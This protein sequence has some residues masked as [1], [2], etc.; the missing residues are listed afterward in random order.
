MIT[1]DPSQ[2][3]FFDDDARVIAV[4]WHRQ[5][6]KDFV[7]AGKAVK[8]A[9]RRKGD[10]FITSLTQ[11]Q[12][13]ASFSKADRFVEAY[14]TVLK[15]RGKVTASEEQFQEYDEAIDHTF[16]RTARTLTLPNGNRVVSLPG[17]NPDTLAGLTGNII[18]TEFGL[19]PQGGYNH[20]RV[21]FPLTTRGYQACLVSTPRSKKTKYYEICS[22]PDIYSVHTCPITRSVAEDGYVLRDNKGNPCTLEAFKKLYNDD[23]GWQREYECQFTGDLDSL[24]TWA[25]LMSAQDGELAT[26]VIH[27]EG[28]NG[29][30]GSLIAWLQAQPAGRFELGW[31]VARTGHLSSLWINHAA[32][33]GKKRLAA[34]VLMH[35]CRFE[36]Q[37]SIIQAVM[38][39]RPGSV[40]AGDATGLGN[41]SNE[42]LATRYR[43]NWQPIVFNGKSKSELGSLGKTAYGDGVQKLPSFTIDT[44]LKFIATDVYSIQCQP[45]GDAADKRLALSETEN[46]LEPRSHCDIAY[47]NLLALFA[48]TLAGG[49]RGALPRPLYEKP[50][51]W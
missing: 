16:T 31:D 30:D 28:D 8:T 48:G 50:L 20:W 14:K 26:R 40:G 27:V 7:A 34:L 3:R 36:T 51:G 49:R 44:S 32:R 17:K 42:T 46:E 9:A 2:R 47:S 1:F 33:D 35:N 22:Q 25:L 5:K 18:L 12:A 10:W 37:R 43:D 29:W 38:N 24:I 19:F 45:T 4:N 11:R 6:G 23:A 21:I 15:M 13:D 41:D 39:C